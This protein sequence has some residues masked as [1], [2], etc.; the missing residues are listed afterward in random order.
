MNIVAINISASI[1]ILLTILIRRMSKKLV[2]HGM[3]SLLWVLIE[4]RLLFPIS[5]RTYFSYLNPIIY[6]KNELTH[7]LKMQKNE[8][9]EFVSESVETIQ[10]ITVNAKEKIF[11][12]WF[13]I[14]LIVTMYFIVQYIKAWKDIQNSILL[15]DDHWL[16]SYINEQKFFRHISVR[17]KTNMNSPATWGVISPTIFFPIDFD[18]Q[19]K[20]QIRFIILHECGHIKY[21][22]F[23][24][25]LLNILL[26][27]LYWYNPFVWLMFC[28]QEHDLEITS[29]RYALHHLDKKQRK[30]YANNLVSTVEKIHRES[31]FLNHYKSN[32]INERVEAIMNFKKMTVGAMVMT[33]LIP[34]GMTTAFASTDIFVNAKDSNFSMEFI[35]PEDTYTVDQSD[36]QELEETNISIDVEWNELQPYVEENV[37]RAASFLI[38]QYYEHVTYGRIPPKAITVSTVVDGYTYRGTLDRVEYTYNDAT[39]KYTGYYSGKIYRQ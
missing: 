33:L 15:Q 8:V 17:L 16:R 20:E 34:M 38:V 11:C 30:A 36:V 29:D 35:V 13:V 23:L 25:K 14:F 7:S 32:L 5:L 21:F 3:F 37:S 27:C 28:Y 26:V 39:D 12:I 18:F 1:M 10:T 4:L 22:H 24:W 9:Y 6:A 2:P 19:D 31:I